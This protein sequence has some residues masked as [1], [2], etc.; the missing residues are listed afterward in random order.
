M[1]KTRF[2]VYG[3]LKR[4]FH[5]NY[6]LGNAKCIGTFVTKPEYTLFDGGFP[7]VERGGDTAIH[8]EVF[9]TDSPQI[10]NRVNDLEGCTG[11]KGHPDN[12]YDI[13]E[14][15]TPFGTANMFVMDKDCSGRKNKITTGIWK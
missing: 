12:W 11:I 15:E 4:G 8:C 7:V 13:D 9:E 5:N 6:V 14:V 3:T 10:V 2:A 1:S